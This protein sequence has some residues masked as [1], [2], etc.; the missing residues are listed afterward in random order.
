MACH[1]TINPVVRLLG[2]IA[3]MVLPACAADRRRVI[4]T[5]TGHLPVM[6]TVMVRRVVNHTIH[7]PT[8]N[9]VLALAQQKSPRV[10][11]RG[12]VF[13]IGINHPSRTGPTHIV[14][15]YASIPTDRPL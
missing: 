10:A 3:V 13:C 15:Q 1:A 6:A 14:Y 11:T 2:M 5:I 8:I 4:A 12:L 7:R 9:D